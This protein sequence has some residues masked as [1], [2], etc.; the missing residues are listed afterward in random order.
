MQD[1]YLTYKALHI[2]FV[3][4]WFSGLFYI[5]RL[6]IYHV[7]ALQKPEQER[8]ILVNQYKI[9]QSRLWYG[10]TWPSMV[11]ALLFGLL[12][13][14][15]EPGYLKFPYMHFKLA[16][17]VLLVIYHMSCQLIFRKLKSGNHRFTSLK[18]RIW[19]EVATLFLVGIVFLIVLKS[20]I[21]FWWATLGILLFGAMLMLA[22]RIYKKIREN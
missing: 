13:L 15:N 9:M 2:V 17:V 19:N 12:L 20:T 5:V 6:F 1:Y 3:V 16:L 8:V 4:T 18:L 14:W 21:S 7:E 10:I 11:L 22:I